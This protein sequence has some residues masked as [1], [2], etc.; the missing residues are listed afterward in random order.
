ML[1]RVANDSNEV[2]EPADPYRAP[3]VVEPEAPESEE[4]ADLRAKFRSAT[5]RGNS[6]LTV[7][8]LISVPAAGLMFDSRWNEIGI[9][10]FMVGLGCL[11][12][13]A[14]HAMRGSRWRRRL[15][16]LGFFR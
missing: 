10:L 16:R 4:I 9:P 15:K 7:G 5:N 6:W 8:L 1:E 14:R 13:A 12:L 11:G 2:P 3:G